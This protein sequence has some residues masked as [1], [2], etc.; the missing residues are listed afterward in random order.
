MSHKGSITREYINIRVETYSKCIEESRELRKLR[1][2]L[3]WL[4]AKTDPPKD[5]IYPVRWNGKPEWTRYKYADGIW[6]V[7]AIG[8]D[9]SFDWYKADEQPDFYCEL[10]EPPKESEG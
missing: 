6:K 7:W 4:N 9:E 2:Q 10:P 8:N 1:E 3:R 5:G